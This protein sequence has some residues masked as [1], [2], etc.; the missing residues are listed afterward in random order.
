MYNNMSNELLEEIEAINSIY[1][2]D[3][4]V[5]LPGNLS[6]NENVYTLVLPTHPVTLRLSFPKNYP[7]ESPTIAGVQS[8]GES[9]PKGYGSH[10]LELARKVLSKTCTPGQVCVFDLV[11]EL[12]KLL[13][14]EEEQDG[15]DNTLGAT[16][17]NTVSDNKADL[18]LSPIPQADT[19]DAPAWIHSETV[20]QKK[21]VFIAHAT[22][23]THP[24]QLPALMISLHAM[25]KSISKATHNISAYRIRSHTQLTPTIAKS[26]SDEA[27][28]T[29]SNVQAIIYQDYDED[30]ETAAGGRLLHL[31]Q[32]MDVWNVLVIVSRWYGGINLGPDRFRIIN[33]VAR[34]VLVAGGWGKGKVRKNSGG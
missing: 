15:P 24:S 16:E 18:S 28:L 9:K 19:P 25:S 32:I 31:M 27:G 12:E 29:D 1:S 14:E 8:I 4:L 30:G 3:S 34:E 17:S 21:S 10:T 7:T 6:D 20:S 2:P 33:Q 5:K 26:R 11:E 13:Q 22:T 23:I